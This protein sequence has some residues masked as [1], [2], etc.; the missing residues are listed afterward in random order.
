MS[1]IDADD[2][3]P[4]IPSMTECSLTYS[5]TSVP[6]WIVRDFATAWF[7]IS[8]SG[9]KSW[10]KQK[11]AMALASLVMGMNVKRFPPFLSIAEQQRSRNG[12]QC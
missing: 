4:P 10:K 7:S 12:F 3:G 5:A 9:S 1:E 8:S 11:L 6:H 2:I